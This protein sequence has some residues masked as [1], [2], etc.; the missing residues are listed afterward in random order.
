MG[1]LKIVSFFKDG[2][3]GPEIADFENPCA[4][5]MDPKGRLLVGGLNRHSQVWVYDVSGQP[6]KV[7]TFGAQ[8][9]IFAGEPGRYGPKKFHWIR[10][11]GFD[12][13]G[14]FYIASVFGSW[15]NVSIELGLTHFLDRDF[16]I[17]TIVASRKCL[18][19]II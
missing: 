14:N 15:Y 16:G 8:G 7:N 6:K 11:L 3:P 12:A 4:L 19:L 2:K 17:L 9:G 10:G 18:L 1:G 5:A 13:A